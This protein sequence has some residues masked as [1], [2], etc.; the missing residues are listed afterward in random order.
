M[1]TAFLSK[2]KKAIG[3]SKTL[4]IAVELLVGNEKKII[5]LQ[6]KNILDREKPTTRVSVRHQLRLA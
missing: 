3:K 5:L 2:R 4:F 6:G 1:S